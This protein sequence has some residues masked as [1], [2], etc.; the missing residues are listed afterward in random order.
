MLALLHE[1]REI[2]GGPEQQRHVV[3]GIHRILGAAMTSFCVLK[4]LTDP[5]RRCVELE[6][7]TRSSQSMHAVVEALRDGGYESTLLKEMCR[8]LRSGSMVTGRRREFVSDGEWYRSETFNALHRPFAF[9]DHVYSLRRAAR[10]RLSGFSV[11]RGIGERPYT[12][13]DKNLLDLFHEELVRMQVTPAAGSEGPRLA[14]REREVLA[15]LLRGASEKEGAFRLCLS[16]HTVHSYVKSIYAAYG[17]S[18]RAEL[19]AHCLGPKSQPEP[20]T[21]AAP[22][23]RGQF[24]LLDY[25]TRPN[26]PLSPQPRTARRC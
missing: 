11:R 12:E 18:S 9:D 2:G 10:S 22:A 15:L 25:R 21:Q 16:Q 1:A 19:L 13:E 5:R 14:P 26:M 3:G 20:G 17:V 23:A 6:V 24:M 4:D 8:R 7:S